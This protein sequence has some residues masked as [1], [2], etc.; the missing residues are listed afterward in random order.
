M[1]LINSFTF[2]KI[3]IKY[4]Q[5]KGSVEWIIIPSKLESQVI[6]PQKSKLDS[7]IQV[8]LVG[9]NYAKGF[10][11]GHTMRNSESTK[12][13]VYIDQQVIESD[14]KMEIQ[15][16]FND[17]HNNNYIHHAVL[18]N[19]IPVVET[20][21]TFQN[22]SGKPQRI[23][24]LS[25][26]SLSNLSPFHKNN[27]IGNL[28]LTRYQ[29][30]WSLEGRKKID[31]IE[32]LQL[33]P[34]WKSS[35]VGLEKYGQVGSMPVRNW[36]PYVA[37]TDQK[38]NITWAACIAHPGSWQIECY[39]LDEDLCI[40]GG[41]ADRDFGHWLKIILPNESFITPKAYVTVVEGDEEFASQQLTSILK[42]S[43]LESNH[44]SED[45]LAIQY[46]EFCTTWGNPTEASIFRT[47]NA[48]KGKKVKYYVIDAGWYTNGYGWENSHGDWELNKEQFPQG[49]ESVTQAIREAEMIPG[50]WFEIETVGIESIA[51]SFF[52]HLLHKDGVVITVGTRRFW[53]MRDPWVFD[54]LKK[55]VVDFLNVYNIGYL[56]IDYN[57]NFGVGFDGEE[58]FGE[59]NRQQ[60]L[61]TQQFIREIQQALPD[62][63]IEN[64]SSGGHRLEYSMMELTDLSSFSDAHEAECIPI[65][66]ASLHHLMLPRQSLIWA[67]IRKEDSLKR[68]YYS[69]I[70]TFLGRMCLSGEINEI[71][72]T[73]WS[74][75]SEC[76]SFYENCKIYIKEGVTTTF[77]QKV[78][79]Y[80]APKGYQ[81]VLRVY[82]NSAL[83]IIHN[84]DAKEFEIP[85]NISQI[86]YTCG[87][88][89]QHIDIRQLD[90]RC[91]F[92]FPDTMMGCALIIGLNTADTIWYE[93]CL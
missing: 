16:I 8:K 30:K 45:N 54:Y 61:A 75:I 35:G 38:M 85:I 65:I 88:E 77:G 69:M 53:D 71:N 92:K 11:T 52:D 58:S 6:L 32:E 42:Q 83:L 41:L 19:N 51:S 24:M 56:K 48:L 93:N 80:R 17:Q 14:E 60:V 57:E 55:R 67:V 25:S 28:L 29:S 22:K 81:A 49:L 43:L 23:E 15:T 12:S 2:N 13:L 79:S 26:F 47:V 40:S 84:F 86:R 72:E 89:N 1:Y 27:P 33:E 82:G 21:S 39:R 46:N 74:V 18:K 44:S 66:A 64:C 5:F 36:F 31:I 91:Q 50:I 90:D 9:D 10:C 87:I 3:T 37:L 63:I 76:I 20:Y 70:S 68:L 78:L 4:Y 73:Q 34:S 59:A 7:M 62:L